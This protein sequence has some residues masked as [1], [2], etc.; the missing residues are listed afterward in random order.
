MIC[1][2]LRMCRQR[3]IREVTER[4]WRKLSSL[5]AGFCGW[6]IRFW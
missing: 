5:F 6:G 1:Q 4:S 3:A 2:M